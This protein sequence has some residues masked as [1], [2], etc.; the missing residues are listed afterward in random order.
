MLSGAAAGLAAAVAW[1]VLAFDDAADSLTAKS[2]AI[3]AEAARP[4][5]P[6]PSDDSLL[7]NVS[8]IVLKRPLFSPDRKAAA[9]AGA[10]PGQTAAD[11]L[12]RLAGVIVGPSGRRAIF[13]DATGHPKV[14]NEGSTIGRFTVR[15]IAPGQVT[16]TSSE[17]ERVLRPTYT[18][19]PASVA[20][21][22][23]PPP[24]AAPFQQPNRGRTR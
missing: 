4:A 23:Q 9:N 3:P 18:S 5:A 15:V 7:P 12:P 1:E 19:V 14:A 21:A 20:G 22:P 2:P 10:T 24:A 13:A 17:G 6:V 16:L 8:T 11:E